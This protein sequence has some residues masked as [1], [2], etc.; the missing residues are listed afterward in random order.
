MSTLPPPLEFG[1]FLP[2]NGDTT[3]YARPVEVPQSIAMFERVTAAAEAAGFSYM[4]VP[5]QTVCWE[6]W[7]AGAMM[8]A[9]S[10]RIKMLIAA[11]PG[12]INPVHLAKMIATFDQLSG[13]RISINLIAG[14]SE[15][16]IASEG[17]RY[18]KEDR[19]ALME[20]EVRILKSLWTSKGPLDFE[21]RFH[22]L[23]GAQVRPRLV[24]QPSPKF[25]LGGGSRE[26]G[27]MSARHS[28]VHLF[29]GD[30]PERIARQMAEIRAM[31][32]TYGRA[33]TIGFGMRLQIICREREADAWAAARQLVAGVSAK[34]VEMTATHFATSVA[35]QRMME[36]A[37]AETDMLGPHLWSGITRVRPGA[38]VAIVG[39][40][41]QCAATLQTFIDLGCHS[42]CL[43][44]WLHDEEAERFGRLVLP[45]VRKANPTRAF[46]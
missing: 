13:G 5:V 29:W 17:I 14:Q 30:Y 42:F 8:A 19:Y 45:L 9:R 1:W 28:D 25:Y 46:T 36:L 6:A 20:E 31:A 18:S 44:G 4:L 26:A 33:G 27:E 39:N 15:T 7:I 41:E 21:G 3:S 38:G 2:T 35:N 43:S 40:P 12:Y 16:E 34:H 37:R 22:S 23:K 11:R 24:Q 10:S 32:A